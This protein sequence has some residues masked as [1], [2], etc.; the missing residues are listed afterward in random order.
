MA[1]EYKDNTIRGKINLISLSN[2]LFRNDVIPSVITA[3]K[4]SSVG[5]PVHMQENAIIV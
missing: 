4:V 2:E 3:Q 1:T 5:V